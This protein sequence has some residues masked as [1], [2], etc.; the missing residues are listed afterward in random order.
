M[1][2]FEELMKPASL[3]ATSRRPVGPA[4]D[5]AVGGKR[6]RQWR[7]V[8]SMATAAV[9]TLQ[10]FVDNEFVDATGDETFSVVNPA[11]GEQL[12]DEPVS[13]AQ[14]V[15]RAVAAAKRAFESFENTTP[16]DRA[17]LLLA[18][19]DLID[20]HGEDIAALEVD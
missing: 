18:L 10:N 7:T 20:E 11:T 9:R 3:R 15:D 14:D 1:T 12:A 8:R 5:R 4:R 16:G 13:S 17:G 2:M 6:P 19:A